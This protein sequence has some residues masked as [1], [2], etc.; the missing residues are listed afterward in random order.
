MRA[1]IAL[2]LFQ[3]SSNCAVR[4]LIFEE[5][6]VFSRW[7]MNCDGRNGNTQARRVSRLWR[8]NIN[9]R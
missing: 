3:T 2:S 6:E 9:H 4:F 1:K 7:Y 8:Q 5:N